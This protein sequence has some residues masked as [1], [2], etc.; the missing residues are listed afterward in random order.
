[1]SEQ[2]DVG[3]P[4]ARA[5]A[6]GEASRQGGGGS[7]DSHLRRMRAWRTTV[8]RDFPACAREV[9]AHYRCRTGQ[10][11]AE[12][13]SCGVSEALVAWCVV[14]AF[15]P[16]EAKALR[17]CMGGDRLDFTSRATNE[18]AREKERAG[19]VGGVPLLCLPSFRRFDQC[20]TRRSSSPSAPLPSPPP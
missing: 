1:M 6:A 9:E 3:D 12:E 8:L 20:L 13:S 17:Q 15:C 14:A 4:A 16:H 2:E 7:G 19:L 18:D 11:G 10:G 5:A